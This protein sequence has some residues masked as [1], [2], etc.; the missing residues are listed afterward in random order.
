M[1]VEILKDAIEGFR[2]RVV[3]ADGPALRTFT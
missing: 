2:V 1:H 3:D